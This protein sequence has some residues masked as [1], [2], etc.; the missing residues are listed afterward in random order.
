MV[1]P[2]LDTMGS[3][4]NV[5]NG[6]EQYLMMSIFLLAYSIGPF[7]IAPLSETFGRVIILQSA[8]LVFLIFNLVCG[9]AQSSKQML[10]FRFLSGLGASAPQS[11]CFFFFFLA[12]WQRYTR[13]R[14]DFE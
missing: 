5:T 3:Q 6:T 4:F 10:A 9:F 2:A 8:N 12:S 7:V 1:A 13:F 14:A 11:V